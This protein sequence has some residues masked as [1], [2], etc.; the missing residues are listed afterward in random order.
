MLLDTGHVHVPISHPPQKNGEEDLPKIEFIFK[1]I[2]CCD[3]T[4]RMK[5][6]TTRPAGLSPCRP[7]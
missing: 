7:A 6:S 5:I 1:K 3:Q 2:K 4:C